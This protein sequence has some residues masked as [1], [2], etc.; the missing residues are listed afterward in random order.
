[1]L[2]EFLSWSVL[3][4][5]TA[6]NFSRIKDYLEISNKYTGGM[7]WTTWKGQN[8][9]LSKM[10]YASKSVCTKFLKS[11]AWWKQPL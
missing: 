8:I 4:I 11:H 7:I 6:N 2:T 10:K 1:M 5:L 3:K 9:N